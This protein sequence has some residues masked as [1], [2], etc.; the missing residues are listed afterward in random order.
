MNASSNTIMVTGGASGIGLAIALRFL[1]RGNKVILVGRAK[2][3]LQEA[4]RGNPDFVIKSCDISKAGERME[5][6]EWLLAEH[7]GLNIVINNAGMQ[8]RINL[9]RA[10]KSWDGYADEIQANLEA[11]IHLAMLLIPHLMQKAE[12]AIINVSS[13]LALT[14]AAWVPIYTATK[15]GLHFF[16]R[17]LRLQLANTSVRVSEILPPM[18]DTD[19]GGSGLHTAGVPLDEFADAVM[20]QLEAG[21][22][23]IGYDT[24]AAAL[25]DGYTPDVVKE[26]AALWWKG[27]SKNSP[28]FDNLV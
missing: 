27:F 10:D 6:C 21:V 22:D 17:A 3:K 2:E 25:A 26:N 4:Q 15:A 7:P 18:V 23:E 28:E 19:L 9:S 11:P 8:R 1:R 12:A 20:S 5:L 24:S 13:G 16:T 14:P